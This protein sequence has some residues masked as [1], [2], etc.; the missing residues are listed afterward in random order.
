M[1]VGGYPL[2]FDAFCAYADDHCDDMPLYLF[3][4]N[5]VAK[6]PQLGRDYSVPKY[7]ADDLFSVLGDKRPDYRCVLVGFT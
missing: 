3:D 2:D 5:F 1:I 4:R 7:F 6:A